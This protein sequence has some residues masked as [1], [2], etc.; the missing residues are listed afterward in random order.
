MHTDAPEQHSAL[1]LENRDAGFV[2]KKLPTPQ[3]DPGSAIVRIDAAGILPYHLNVIR[4]YPIPIP[5]VGGFSAIGHIVATGSD[6]VTLKPGHLVYIDC[7]IHARDNPDVFFLSAIIEGFT[8]ESK[9][10]MRHAWRDGSFAEYMKVPLE[11][12]IQMNETRLCKELAYSIPELMYM[13]YLLVPY[14][15]LKDIEILPGE[16]LVVCPATGSY[17]GAAVQV[18]LAM[19]ARVIAVGR[20]EEKLE[21]LKEH[22]VKASHGADL[23][24][25]IV[26]GDEDED[27]VG[28]RA[29][30][31]IDAVLDLTP[32]S[33][34]SSPHTKSAIRALRRGGRVSLMGST[35]N[36][37][38][39]EIL[40]NNIALKGK[41][42][43][44]IHRRYC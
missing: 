31:T 43:R 34:A 30:G 39:S 21:K 5:L 42:F 12:C 2:L 44:H 1:V 19:G 13:A 29:F 14:G 9:H 6:A 11:N 17:G 8:D 20:S 33:A 16:S 15:G 36:I 4:H 26:K 27:L 38:A 25:F 37:G 10:L 23:E 41:D 22:V 32:P 40:T 7:V 24:T 18:A 3:P 35:Q 28:L